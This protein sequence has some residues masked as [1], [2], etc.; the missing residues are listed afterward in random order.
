MPY[1]LFYQTL[2]QHRHKALLY[3]NTSHK[4]GSY[5]SLKIGFELSAQRTKNLVADLYVDNLRE[6]GTLESCTERMV[7][8]I[9]Y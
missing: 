3:V 8:F 6:L 5:K 7:Y 9:F 2:R 4:V 1:I